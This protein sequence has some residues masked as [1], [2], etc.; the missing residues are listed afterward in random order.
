MEK[1]YNLEKATAIANNGVTEYLTLLKMTIWPLAGF[2]PMWIWYQTRS[3]CISAGGKTNITSFV[4]ASGGVVQTCWISILVFVIVPR[5]NLS[6]PT[7]YAIFFLSD[8]TKIIVYEVLF[9]KLN[10]GKNLTLETKDPETISEEAQK[11]NG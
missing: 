6:F 5:T 3:R 4:D 8:I 2:M 9:H 1:G 10:W 7:A 11:I